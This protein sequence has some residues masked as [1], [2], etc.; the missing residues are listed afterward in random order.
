ML[1]RVSTGARRERAPGRVEISQLS[2]SSGKSRDLGPE[3]VG[4]TGVARGWMFGSSA[5]FTYLGPENESTRLRSGGHDMAWDRGG[6]CLWLAPSMF[7][8]RCAHHHIMV[9][10]PLFMAP[11]FACPAFLLVLCLSPAAFGT[12]FVTKQTTPLSSGASGL[13]CDVTCRLVNFGPTAAKP[14]VD[15]PPYPPY[16]STF[17]GFRYNGNSDS[18]MLDRTVGFGESDP[19]GYTFKFDPNLT[20]PSL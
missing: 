10:L 3:E 4:S 19:F 11:F 8:V 7:I 12:C 9:G 14:T 1:S 15:C 17:G 13:T 5:T 20:P 18:C 2:T 6:L 16:T